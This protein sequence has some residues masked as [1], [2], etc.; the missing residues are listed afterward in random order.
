MLFNWHSWAGKTEN[1][2]KETKEAK[3]SIYSKQGLSKF[4]MC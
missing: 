3:N 2:Y 1:A 4:R